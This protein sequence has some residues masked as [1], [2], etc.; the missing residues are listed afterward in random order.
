ML[1]TKPQTPESTPETSPAPAAEFAQ[2]EADLAQRE[3]EF[4][5][6]Q[7]EF[8][9]RQAIT[10]FLDEQVQAGRLLPVDK[11]PFVS[12]FAALP[13]DLEIEFSQGDETV[14]QPSAEFL[15]GWLKRLPKQVHYGEVAPASDEFAEGQPENPTTQVR[16]I[17]ER[18]FAQARQ[19]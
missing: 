4:A 10:P 13:D 3:A 2:R 18:K 7:A 6:Q 19:R 11:E 17:L 15:K 16:K 8:A 5:Q 14:K 9:R 12:L 1:T